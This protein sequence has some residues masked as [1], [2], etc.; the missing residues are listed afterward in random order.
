MDNP[1]PNRDKCS[2]ADYPSLAHLYTCFGQRVAAGGEDV[3]SYMGG[4]RAFCAFRFLHVRRPSLPH[5]F[6]FF[7]LF[8]ISSDRLEAFARI[9]VPF[10]IGP[11]VPTSSIHLALLNET[12]ICAATITSTSSSSNMTMNISMNGSASVSRQASLARGL[13]APGAAERASSVPACA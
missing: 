2:G 11:E 7:C 4:L 8:F 3:F 13:T 10:L 6:P 12:P 5:V 1:S 9:C